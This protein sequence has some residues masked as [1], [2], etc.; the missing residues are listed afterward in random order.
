MDSKDRRAT[1][2]ATSRATADTTKDGSKEGRC[3]KEMELMRRILLAQR[4]FE[5]LDAGGGPDYMG[6]LR[7][8]L[9]SIRDESLALVDRLTKC[10]AEIA[11][12]ESSVRQNNQDAMC[13]AASE[14]EVGA[15]AEKALTLL[16]D[17]AAACPAIDWTAA[18]EY[19]ETAVDIQ[20]CLLNILKECPAPRPV[21]F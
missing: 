12:L 5:E 19:G 21:A 17:L 10:Y 3:M 4:A 20:N 9:R 11:S 15:E 1:S 6:E 16:R 8:H 18:G 7:H 13:E 14:A 2:R